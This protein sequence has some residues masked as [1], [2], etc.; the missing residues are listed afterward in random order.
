MISRVTQQTIQ[1]SALAGLQANLG[2]VS[3]LQ[4]RMSS[5]KKIT[6]P[7]DDPSGSARTM[8]LRADKAA[9]TQATRNADDGIAWLGTTDNAMQS[10]ITALRRARDLTVQ[11][12][13][14]GSVGA[15][16]TRGDR[17]RD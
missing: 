2:R 13:S 5:G 9:A 3:D 17:H 14:S 8:A 12:A 11:A 6:K 4:A 7:S 16:S 1:H 15:S 10:S